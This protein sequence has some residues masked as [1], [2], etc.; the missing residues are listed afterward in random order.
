MAAIAIPAYQGYAA[1]AQQVELESTPAATAD[2]SSTD[3]N[4]T[5]ISEV[6]PTTQ[7]APGALAPAE[8]VV[9]S[10]PTGPSFD[11]AKAATGIEIQICSSPELASLDLQLS[12]TYKR[13]LSDS[14]DKAAEKREQMDWIKTKR[15]ACRDVAC[16]SVAYSSRIEEMET[17]LQYLNKPAEFR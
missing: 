1:R 16:L 5:D 15:N 7:L 12:E 17:V 13:L 2:T 4:G 11:C 10:V 8:P 3:I 14:Q 9:E 6:G